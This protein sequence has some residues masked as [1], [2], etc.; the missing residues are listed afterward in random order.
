VEDLALN[1]ADAN[2]VEICIYILL[3]KLLERVERDSEFYPE[4][5]EALAEEKESLKA[6]ISEM[7]A[8]NRELARAFQEERESGEKQRRELVKIW[9]GSRT[10]FTLERAIRAAF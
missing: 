6:A 3:G 9:E 5:A 10:K 2:S 1:S 4:W 8:S 7:E